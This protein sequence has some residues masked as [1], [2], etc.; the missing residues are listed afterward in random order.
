MKQYRINFA[1]LAADQCQYKDKLWLSAPA[2]S[3]EKTYGK[4]IC[5]FF[6]SFLLV[7]AQ[8]TKQQA[9][10]YKMFHAID[11]CTPPVSGLFAGTHQS[12]MRTSEYVVKLNTSPM[13]CMCTALTNPLQKP[14][15][16]LKGRKQWQGTYQ[17]EPVSIFQYSWAHTACC[18]RKGPSIRWINGIRLY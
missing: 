11:E 12:G 6:F 4:K 15:F 2:G 3:S 5:L 17:S 14:F 16:L 13:K 7:S 8:I 10:L 9:L 1:S 18:Y